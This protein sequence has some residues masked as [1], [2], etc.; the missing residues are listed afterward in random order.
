MKWRSAY[1][2]VI[3]VLLLFEGCGA[4]DDGGTPSKTPT[5]PPT[6]DGAPPDST[7][8]T[9]NEQTAIPREEQS[10]S[11]DADL[12][13]PGPGKPGTIKGV[14]KSP[15][16]RLVAGVVFIVR[17]EG[18]QFDPP[19]QHP[20]MDQK[21]KIFTPHILP[22]LAGSTVDFPNTDDVRHN[23]F[24]VDGSPQKFNLGQ[25]DVGV[26][27]RVKFEKLGLTELGCNVHTEMQGFVL[28]LQNP[29]FAI[30]SR[31]TGNFVIDDV[32]PGKYQLSFFHEKVQEKSIEV[33]VKPGA[34]TE[35]EFT[36]LKRK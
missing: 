15:Y 33:T 14:L 5:I 34:E 6:N 24:S 7:Q 17:V 28:A 19:E 10:S 3:V 25:Y 11:P 30:S 27:K 9:T 16:A 26:V 29:Y 23:V 21:N 4:K 13:V 18:R 31:G 12:G 22:V 8:A 20:A 36:D 35:V 32:P 1:S 2:M